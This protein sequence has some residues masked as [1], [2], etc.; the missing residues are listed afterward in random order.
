LEDVGGNGRIIIF[1]PKI[2]LK[3]IKTVGVD[4][5]YLPQDRVQWRVFPKAKRI[6]GSVTAGNLLT[7]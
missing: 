3:E 5:I 4:W 1:R 6:F 7:R 2:E